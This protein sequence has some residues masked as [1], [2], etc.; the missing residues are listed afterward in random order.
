MVATVYHIYRGLENDF[1][2]AANIANVLQDSN[3]PVIATKLSLTDTNLNTDTKYY[4]WVQACKENFC[5]EESVVASNVTLIKTPINLGI[6]AQGFQSI[7]ITWDGVSNAS[8]YNIYRSNFHSI[9]TVSDALPYSQ[10]QNNYYSDTDYNGTSITY[11]WVRACTVDDN[12]SLFSDQLSI[13]P[14]V[15][16]SNLAV[17]FE[18]AKDNEQTVRLVFSWSPVKNPEYKISLQK[19]E[20]D[21]QPYN[22]SDLLSFPTGTQTSL[23]NTVANLAAN[24]QYKAWIQ[25]CRVRVDEDDE[26]NCSLK[27]EARL[28]YT[29][30]MLSPSYFAHINSSQAEIKLRWTQNENTAYYILERIE[31][32][33]LDSAQATVLST[34]RGAKYIAVGD[35]TEDGKTVIK[36]TPN[37]TETI[38]TDDGEITYMYYVD[39]NIK[40]QLD[41]PVDVSDVKYDLASSFTQESP[42]AE[43][44]Q[45]NSCGFF[46]NYT[47]VEK[48]SL[49]CSGEYRYLLKAVSSIDTD[50]NGNKTESSSKPVY[51]SAKF[52]APVGLTIDKSEL[53]A[54]AFGIKWDDTTTQEECSDY[55]DNVAALIP[56]S[57]NP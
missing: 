3:D 12:C 43:K 38:T 9:T 17:E 28:T 1:L 29:T 31:I 54:N 23:E 20:D 48:V 42:T 26:S 41:R 50:S 49:R 55:S 39:R 56:A 35:Y 47:L 33:N 8:Y 52:A 32:G 16:P 22:E 51:A 57:N 25:A 45:I 27:N 6:S 46:A 18:Q 19:L 53:K 2:K 36:N 21:S 13:K 5:S 4:Y 15:A 11:Y 24:T 37:S 40:T 7:D 44:R 34:E 14:K 10:T 30:K